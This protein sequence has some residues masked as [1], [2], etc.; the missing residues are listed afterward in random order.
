M[1]SHWYFYKNIQNN[2]I[3]LFLLQMLEITDDYYTYFLSDFYISLNYKYR[4][5][6]QS[7]K[8]AQSI[9]LRLFKVELHFW[10]FARN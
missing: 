8:Q 7:F 2:I 9:M 10:T 3:V 1:C 4:R 6:L 5:P